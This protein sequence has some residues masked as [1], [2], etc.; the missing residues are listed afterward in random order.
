MVDEILKA[1]IK[2]REEKNEKPKRAPSVAAL[3][4]AHPT[5][6]Q[7]PNPAAAVAMAAASSTQ[8]TGRQTSARVNNRNGPQEAEALGGAGVP[9]TKA[10]ADG[11]SMLNEM[12]LMQ[13]QD[14]EGVKTYV[15]TLVYNCHFFKKEEMPLPL[16]KVLDN[17]FKKIMLMIHPDKM[18]QAAYKPLAAEMTKIVTDVKTSWPKIEFE[19][20]IYWPLNKDAEIRSRMAAASAVVPN[21][22]AGQKKRRR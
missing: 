14:P 15:T 22:W 3:R 9:M 13:N 6:D 8:D 16:L 10:V 18:T 7:C 5:K 12:S 19:T 2:E 21:R 1:F 20:T 17:T 4:Q 11:I